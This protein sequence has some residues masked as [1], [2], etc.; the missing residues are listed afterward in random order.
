MP[1]RSARTGGTGEPASAEAEPG[2]LGAA[3]PRASL[4]PLS[5]RLM[6]LNRR[7]GSSSTTSAHA[8][9]TG[10]TL[11][12]ALVAGRAQLAAISLLRGIVAIGAFPTTT[13]RSWRGRII[14]PSSTVPLL[15]ECPSASAATAPTP[16]LLKK[17]SG[18]GLVLLGVSRVMPHKRFRGPLALHRELLRPRP[19]PAWLMKAGSCYSA[20]SRRGAW[21]ERRE[22]GA[23]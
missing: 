22:P 16:G 5:S 14:A 20:R 7:R 11:E 4:S 6:H 9:Y 21:L 19:R 3:S 8:F 17:L 12:N 18:L 23:G 15:I 13:P 1:T 10:T 2:D